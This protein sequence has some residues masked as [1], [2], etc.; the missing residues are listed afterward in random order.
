MA[1]AAGL[2]VLVAALVAPLD[3]V[4][5]LHMLQHLL[6]VVVAA[7]LIALGRPGRGSPV[8][9]WLAWPLHVAVL[10]VWHV[11]ALFEAALR[12]GPLHGVEHLTLLATGL[13]F[14][15]AAQWLGPAGR[16]GYLF[17]AAVASS[18]LGILLV[19]SRPPWY[20]SYPSVEDQ[21]AAG[22]LM[23]IGGGAAYL[24][25]MLAAMIGW[26]GSE[27]QPHQNETAIRV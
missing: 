26:L 7:P 9:P 5:S 13:L 6:L 4:F 2:V 17:A 20:A 27:P 14:W 1:F 12:L 25:A 15:Y 19:F 8:G 11:P 21:V 22:L 16:I 3:G 18:L 10:Y 23:W 24:V